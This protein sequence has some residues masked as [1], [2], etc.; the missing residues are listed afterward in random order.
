MTPDS[1]TEDG[2]PNSEP[3][4][5]ALRRAARWVAVLNIA[6]FGVEFPAH[7]ITAVANP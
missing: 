3:Q 6:Y 4:A 5:T 7:S 2:A 1:S